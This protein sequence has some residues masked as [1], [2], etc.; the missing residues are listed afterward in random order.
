MTL[1]RSKLLKTIENNQNIATNTQM[2]RS[3]GE[4]R[5]PAKNMYRNIQHFLAHT[6]LTSISHFFIRALLRKI[7][8]Y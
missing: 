2:R 3:T 1:L 6:D 7:P 5:Y 8:I 4:V